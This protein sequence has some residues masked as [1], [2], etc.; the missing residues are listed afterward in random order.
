M[1]NTKEI[2]KMCK[3]TQITSRTDLY[4]AKK[5]R[6]KKQSKLVV[7]GAVLR[8]FATCEIGLITLIS[9]QKVLKTLNTQGSK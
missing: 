4:K 1:L 5:K 7:Q 9:T 6:V 3:G 2:I 8:N